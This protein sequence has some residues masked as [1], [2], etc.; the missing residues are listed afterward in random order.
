MRAHVHMRNT[1]AVAPWCHQV[2]FLLS[3]T[4]YT[5]LYFFGSTFQ[6]TIAKL[7][8]YRSVVSSLLLIDHF[9]LLL[10]LNTAV[11][12]T[13]RMFPFLFHVLVGVPDAETWAGTVQQCV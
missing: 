7:R 4:F 2:Y 12:A 8:M 5:F 1:N 6:S 10:W 13:I 3:F 11:L 9:R